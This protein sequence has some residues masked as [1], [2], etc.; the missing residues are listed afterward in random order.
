[1]ESIAHD[2]HCV[3]REMVVNNFHYDVVAN[4]K[5]TFLSV[6]ILIRNLIQRKLLYPE[7]QDLN[8]K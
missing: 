3:I 6:K 5:N 7:V 4:S 1:M 8:F 2:N